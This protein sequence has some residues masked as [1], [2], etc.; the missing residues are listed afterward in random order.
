[1]K[2]A[3]LAAILL[4]SVVAGPAAAQ[5][6]DASSAYTPP[7]DPL[8]AQ[9]L[10]DWR[11]LKFGLLMHWGTYSQWG[12]VESWSLCPEDEPWCVRRGPHAADWHGY[13]QAYEALQREFNPVRFD[14]DKWAAAA[15][16]AGM[17][18]VVFTTKHHDGFCMFDTRQ[19]DYRITHP[20]SPF[21]AHPRANVAREVFEAFRKKGFMTGAYFS[22]PDW[23]TP[24]YW[25]KYFPPKDRNVSYD[26]KKYPA[27]WEAFKRFTHAQLEELATGYGRLDIL[28]L[29]G[30]WV[31]PFHTIDPRVEWQRTIPYDQ[32]IDMPAIARMMRTHQ[33]GMLIVDRTVPGEYENY[34]TPEQSVPS[35]WL[36][37]PWESCIT[38]GNAWGH[39]PNE[40]YKSARKV[41]HLLT[42]V[43]SRNGSL[44]LNVGPRPDGEWDSTAY[45]RLAEIGAW[46]R[47]NGEAVYGAE[48]DSSL[49]PVGPWV[50]T[51]KGSE[52]YAIYQ[53]VEGEAMP[54]E[55]S[56]PVPRSALVKSVT[57]LGR[58]KPLAFVREAAGVRVR[59]SAKGAAATPSTSP[60]WVF[61]V[62]RPAGGR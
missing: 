28:W 21:S 19:T 29:D 4:L 45:A 23:N 25:W 60:A 39:V 58:E 27:R 10:A 55:L 62:S 35:T 31:R 12:I 40:Q 54:A 8:V 5:H 43:V 42:T 11:K 50:Y 36:P 20:N 48:A 59:L 61:R 57:L 7:S 14:P 16:G 15:E 34:A 17:R 53:A 46:M 24:D 2:S 52:V 41:I 47:A 30:G 3:I 26:P 9:R 44:L 13:R 18:Y 32:D 51:R 38:L 1:M 56:V 22:K 49:R 6:H 33:P 37:Y